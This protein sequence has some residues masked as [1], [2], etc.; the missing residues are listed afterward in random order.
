M[1]EKLEEIRK[2][3][4]LTQ[5]QVADESEITRQYYNMIEN[6]ERTPTVATAKK[7]AKVLNIEW[8][9]MFDS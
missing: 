9:S 3:K 7:I 6:G 5:Q 2:S 8:T 4:N 1:K